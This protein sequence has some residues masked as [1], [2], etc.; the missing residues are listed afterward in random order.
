MNSEPLNIPLKATA[1]EAKG[2]VVARNLGLVDSLE[3]FLYKLKPQTAYNVYVSGQATPVGSFKT[4]PVGMANGT[5]I[6][7]MREAISSL[8]AKTPA[9]SV[10]YVVEAGQPADA[11]KAVL[12]SAQ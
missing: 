3:V 10:I 4:N 11:A 12:T 7:P 1:G 5:A 6:G 2:F 8:S 9:P